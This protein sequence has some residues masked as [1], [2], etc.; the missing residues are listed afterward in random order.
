MEVSTFVVEWYALNSTFPPRS[1]DYDIVEFGLYIL[2]PLVDLLPSSSTLRL[3][4]QRG[5]SNDDSF[6]SN[7]ILCNCAKN[8]KPSGY[9][10]HYRNRTFDLVYTTKQSNPLN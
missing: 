6:T 10:L 5:L 1:F 4:L 3:L 2:E 8:P 9:R 7:H